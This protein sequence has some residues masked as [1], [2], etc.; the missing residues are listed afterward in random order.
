MA[1][2]FFETTNIKLIS[3][4]KEFYGQSISHLV[5]IQNLCPKSFKRGSPPKVPRKLFFLFGLDGK[6]RIDMEVH[7]IHEILENHEIHENRE[8]D[9]IQDVH[10]FQ[11]N[12]ENVGVHEFHEKS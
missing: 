6:H 11:E 2:R 5:S 8:F 7:K 1:R 9:E 12:H 4:L 10:E 3:T